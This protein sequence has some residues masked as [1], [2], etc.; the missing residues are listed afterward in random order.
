MRSVR[1]GDRPAVVR[2]HVL[3]HG[4]HF[5]D[6]VDRNNTTMSAWISATGEDVRATGTPD[7]WGNDDC[8]IILE[9]ENGGAMVN[10]TRDRSKE[11]WTW[12]IE[13]LDTTVEPI[14][15]TLDLFWTA[16]KQVD[17]DEST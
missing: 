8:R 1:I 6:D 13:A 3:H 7:G 11:Q 17:P 14:R 9:T 4:R 16:T 2:G 10:A 12:R 5:S 15:F